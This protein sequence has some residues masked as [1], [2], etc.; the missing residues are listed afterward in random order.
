MT[1]LVRSAGQL[2][3]TP[4]LL[5][6]LVVAAW[7]GLAGVAGPLPAP[8]A[9]A[10]EQCVGVVVDARLLGGSV[11]TGCAKGDPESGL[12]V[13]T[14]AGFSYAFLP[15]QA[16]LVCQVDGVPAC[17]ETSTTTYWSYWHRAK[18]SSTWVY[19]TSGAGSHDPAPGSTEAWVWQDGGR[20][21]PPDVA[22]R[23][24]CPPSAGS[25]SSS[26]KPSGT[27]SATRASSPK[28]SPAASTERAAA[29]RTKGSAGR[30]SSI[31]PLP[32]T[33]PSAP[34][35][36]PAESSAGTPGTSGPA[37]S[38]PRTTPA[39]SASAAASGGA[40]Q[41]VGLAAGAVLVVALGAAAIARSRRSG[42]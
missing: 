32:A 41:W 4:A 11:R 38:S 34:R 39:A 14:A 20:R 25:S 31:A 13:L 35:T 5:A 22:Q 10:A 9:A 23:T 33:T 12:K 36:G 7:L 40:G 3:A 8:R 19:S 18:G 16:G 26:P 15:R 6:T 24:I 1:R 2:P 30:T 17:E 21:E 29:D 42:P 28:P 37:T 27:G